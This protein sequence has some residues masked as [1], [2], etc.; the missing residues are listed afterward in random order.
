MEMM[1]I[2]MRSACQYKDEKLIQD[3]LQL[4]ETACDS[5][6]DGPRAIARMAGYG[7]IVERVEGDN[8]LG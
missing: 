5:Q 8:H 2:C 6:L 3:I 4:A 1:G 7:E